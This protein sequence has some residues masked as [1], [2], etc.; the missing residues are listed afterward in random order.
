M[1]LW[2]GITNFDQDTFYYLIAVPI[3]YVVNKV[4]FNYK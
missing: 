3:L 4:F 2:E 1:K